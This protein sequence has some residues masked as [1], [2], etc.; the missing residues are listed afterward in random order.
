MSCIIV[1]KQNFL[2]ETQTKPKN[3]NK[4]V[5][6]IENNIGMQVGRM[7]Y[8][9]AYGSNGNS[10]NSNSNSRIISYIKI[11]SRRTSHNI[12]TMK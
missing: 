6:Q 4:K 8:V 12:V 3:R 7:G 11:S 2:N 9:P 10:R 1:P 5:E